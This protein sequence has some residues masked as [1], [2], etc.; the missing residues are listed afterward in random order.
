M[1]L[2][3]NGKM[4]EQSMMKKKVPRI[5]IVRSDPSIVANLEVVENLWDVH[6]RTAAHM[7]ALHLKKRI[8]F[9][10]TLTY[11][12]FVFLSDLRLDDCHNGKRQI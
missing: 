7:D 8:N 12:R 3:S 2:F 1:K 6:T 11:K 5:T 10:I 9:E 4:K